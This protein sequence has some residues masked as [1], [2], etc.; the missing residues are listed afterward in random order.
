MVFVFWRG[1]LSLERDGRI[2]HCCDTA[3]AV[4]SNPT[5]RSKTLSFRWKARVA[6]S[7]RAVV[8]RDNK[9]TGSNAV[10]GT[11]EIV[12]QFVRERRRGLSV[13][14][15]CCIPTARINYMQHVSEH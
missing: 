10:A 7:G 2:E 15:P 11:I 14:A 9:V 8:S 1:Q 3:M 13:T 6:Q 5:P 12:L 4:G